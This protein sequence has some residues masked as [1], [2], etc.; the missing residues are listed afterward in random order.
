VISRLEN[1]VIQSTKTIKPRGSQ[2][3]IPQPP[4]ITQ[5]FKQ[6]YTIKATDVI[7]NN[8]REPQS[9]SLLKRETRSSVTMNLLAPNCF[10]DLRRNATLIS[11][12]T[13]ICD[14]FLHFIAA[15]DK[16]L[17]HRSRMQE[18]EPTLP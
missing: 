17:S 3:L 9:I 2:T 6:T 16:I 10:P 14:V 15:T 11:C 13:R 1:L 5:K 12:S 8:G 7:T 18:Y 4:K